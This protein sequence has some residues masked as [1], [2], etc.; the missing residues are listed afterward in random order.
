MADKET[1]I[2]VSLDATGVES[3]V[4]RARRSMDAF[5][6]SQE[7]AAQRTQI[8]QAAIAEANS[9]GSKASERAINSLVQQAAKMADTYGMNSRQLL[10]Y[11]AS[12]LGVSDAIA[13]YIEKMN[14]IDAANGQVVG[15][16]AAVGETAEAAAARISAM[17]AASLEATAALNSQNDAAERYAASV[18]A[19]A[20][21]ATAAERANTGI[22]TSARTAATA[23]AAVTAEFKA[24][25]TTIGAEAEKVAEALGRQLTALTATQAQMVE[26]DAQ[27][28]GFTE[29]ETAQVAAIAK[30]IE[31]RKQ[32]IALGEE[33]AA[34]YAVEATAAHGAAGATA[35]VTAELG[36]LGREAASGNFTRL[37]SSFTRFLSLAGALD[38]LLNPLS[39]TIA[40]VGAAMYMVA[41]QNEKMNEALLLTG[42]YAGVTTD[43][44]RNMATAATAGGATFNT[45]AEA[46]TELAMTGR[47]TGEEIA[48]LGRSAAD[49]ATYTSVS[50]K[51]MVDDFTKLAD[52]P[53]KASVKLND[54]YHYLTA[55]TYDQIAALERQGDATGAAKVAVEA[56]SQAM[57]DRTK[58]IAANEGIILAGWRDIKAMINGAIEAV[59]S[60]GAA[61]TPGQ[62]VAR[63]QD[64]KTARLPIGQW[65]SEDEAELQK[66]IAARDAAIKAAQDKA[67]VERQ[68]QQTIDAKH[69]YDTFNQ[70]FATPAEK[71]AKEI[72]KYLD[73]IA[74][75]LG[76]SAEQQLADEANIDAKYKDP[77]TPKPKAYKDDAGERMLQQLHD[78]QAALEAQLSVTGKLTTAEGE[79]AK[80][81]QQI[82]D[83]KNKTLTPQQ[84]SLVKDQ[85]AIRAQ[86]QRNVEL[87]KEI[88]HREQVAKLQER[89]AQ[90]D[91]SIASYQRGQNDQYGRQLDAFGMGSDALKNV[92]AVKSIYAEY[93]RLQEQLDKAT[94]KDLIG[95]ADYMKASADIKAG[96]DQSLQ[97]YDAYYASLKAKQADWTN[98]AT[99][100]IANYMDSAHNM[101][102]QTESAVTNVAK[103]M[104]DAFVSFATTGKLNFKSLADSIIADIVRM[105]AKAA[106]SG[107]F[108]MAISAAG[109]YFGNGLATF[110]ANV[111]SGNSLDNLVNNTG[112][113]GTVPARASGGSVDAGT[114]Y[115]VGEKGP[116]LFNPGTSGTIIPNHAI[117]SS[118]GGGDIS[119]SVPVSVQGGGSAD[120]QRNAGDLGMKIKQ[121]VQAV[122]QSERKQGGALWK[123]QNGIA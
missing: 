100:G 106:I 47:L 75:P 56:F 77:K 101:A 117:T 7:A 85:D 20:A 19:M 58:E 30:E 111:Q 87:E 71:R 25:S 96:L 4:E 28:A 17:V 99:A 92:Q 115:L 97:D 9:N 59:G 81:N 84:A 32:Q 112:G 41:S 50:V 27:M 18:D 76:L 67:R 35:G 42:G 80:L 6:A 39:L 72:Q 114:T 73:T 44:L 43:Q 66:A 120:D 98:G 65:S 90:I 45:A 89:S 57:D 37:A 69:A 14:A 11:K 49:A 104:E 83:W 86:L 121:A 123:M 38:L 68:N 94:P 21:A 78:Q 26:Y 29:A 74:G 5:I 36:V 16:T 53:V 102:A 8:A 118:S 61:A 70:Q 23:Q 3:G 122:L 103:S 54:Q 119:V 88:A 46:V 108:N 64:N 15:S 40:G 55:A 10:A 34:M 31:L 51:Q 93:Q 2:R 109:S 107:L 24:A 110:G 13:P 95:G 22:A 79:L 48:N 62:V 116:E 60:F 63:L 12:L 52:E 113:W 1:L 82:S 33:M 91:A 105:Q